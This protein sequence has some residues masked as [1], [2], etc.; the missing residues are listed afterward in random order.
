[1]SF[2]KI[3]DYSGQI[4]TKN[5]E[6]I[7]KNRLISNLQK[8]R[9]SSIIKETRVLTQKF[10]GEKLCGMTLNTY[11]HVFLIIFS[12]FFYLNEKKS[13]RIAVSPLL[14]TRPCAPSVM[15]SEASIYVLRNTDFRSFLMTKN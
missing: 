6:L 11:Y 15:E 1:M 10:M 13:L 2:D 8:I 9:F 14:P 12:E 5:S 4:C 7:I 3:S